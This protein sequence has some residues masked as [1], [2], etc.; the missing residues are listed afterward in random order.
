M[1]KKTNAPDLKP[2]K[3]QLFALDYVINYAYPEFHEE[4]DAETAAAIVNAEN[5]MFRLFD[6]YGFTNEWRKHCASKGYA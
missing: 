5:L 4:I 3:E 1:K 2:T 6:Q